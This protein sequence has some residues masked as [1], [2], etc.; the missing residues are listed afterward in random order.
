MLNRIIDHLISKEEETL[1]TRLDYLRDVAG[2]SES[3]FLKIALA[4]PLT[5]HRQI[6][7]KTVFHL[8]ILVT[9]Q[10]EDCGEC[11]EIVVQNALKEG[12]PSHDVRAA[13]DKSY[14]LLPAPLEEAC[15]FAQA[16]SQGSEDTGLRETLRDRYGTKG[17]I[18]LGMV[19]AGARLFPTLRRVLGH[20][21]V[22]APKLEF[23]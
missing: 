15:A 2:E 21:R 7:P 11:L 13:L 18:E 6:L 1:G 9:T 14:H 20:A 22:S 3:A 12:V 23:T 19:I 5:R 8:A 16:L 17:L 10:H 4:I